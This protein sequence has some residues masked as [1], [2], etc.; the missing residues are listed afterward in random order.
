MRKF[1][2]LQILILFSFSIIAQIPSGYYNA[3]VGKADAA[4]KTALFTKIG[5][6]TERS[7]NQLWT[8]F[9]TTDKRVDGKVW[10][11]Y[12]TC[13]FT[14]GT[15]QDSGSG[16]SAE[17]QYYNREHSFPKSWFKDAYP[18]YSDLFHLYPTD[19]FVNAERGNFPF[20]ETTSPTTSY[21]NGSKKGT[22]SFSGY[23]GT[24]FEPANEYKGDFARTYFYMVTAYESVVNTWNTSNINAS[25]HL[26]GT[27]YP[28]LNTWSVALLLKWTR[29]D[30]VSTKEINRNNAV[31]GIQNNRNPFIDYP[32]LAEHI[33]GTKKGT[34]WSLTSGIEN[35]KVEFSISQPNGADL[36]KINTN[37]QN[38]SYRIVSLNGILVEQNKLANNTEINTGHLKE[39]MYFIEVQSDNR[40]A[41]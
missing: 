17:C 27:K 18:M 36:L 5:A 15:H 30:P 11:M 26:D 23:L 33:W 40:K 29:Q 13:T 19:K 28:A 24:V 1:L 3:A 10:D 12:S 35:V 21:S 8:D 31:Y 34:P 22:S 7:Y 16:G 4:L 37:E 2:F 38:C 20:G 32:I 41:I 25:P 6:H 14:F 39:G 9:Q